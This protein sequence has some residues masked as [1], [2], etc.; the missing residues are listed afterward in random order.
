MAV[1]PVAATMALAVPILADGPSWEAANPPLFMIPPLVLGRLPAST[2]KLA[3]LFDFLA[4]ALIMA[5]ASE[6]RTSRPGS[7]LVL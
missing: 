6:G 5:L 7:L 4:F 1:I 3:V 2:P